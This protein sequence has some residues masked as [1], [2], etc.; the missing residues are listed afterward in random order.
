V[1]EHHE[2]AEAPAHH[3]LGSLLQGPGRRREHELARQVVTHPLAVRVLTRSEGLEHVALG[4]DPDPVAL[5]VVHH[6]CADV[7]RGHLHRGL[8][9]GVVR[10]E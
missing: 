8:P 10:P 3:R 1:L 5:G 7:A 6:R 9:E 2:V 4:E